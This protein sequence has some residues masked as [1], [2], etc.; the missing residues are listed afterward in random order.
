MYYLLEGRPLHNTKI[1]NIMHQH[2]AST[3]KIVAA[4]S[5]AT[6]NWTVIAN[7]VLFPDV[8]VALGASVVLVHARF[9]SSLRQ[10]VMVN[11]VSFAC[12]NNVMLK[13]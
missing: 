12:K 2:Y 11:N 1:V 8:L 9:T 6:S 4:L 7:V 10:K 3:Y 13:V 5:S